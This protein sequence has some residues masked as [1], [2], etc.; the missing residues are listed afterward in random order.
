MTHRWHYDYPNE[1]DYDFEGVF[2]PDEE[3]EWNSYPRDAQEY[4]LRCGKQY[5]DTEIGDHRGIDPSD[6][7]TFGGKHYDKI[8]LFTLAERYLQDVKEEEEE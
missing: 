5:H 3:D 4:A 8:V 7:V 6:V 2:S 1:W